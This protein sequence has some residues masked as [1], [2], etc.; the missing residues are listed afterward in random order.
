M[1]PF[2]NISVVSVCLLLLSQYNTKLLPVVD[3]H[4]LL[5]IG[6][7]ITNM[8]TVLMAVSICKFINIVD[9]SN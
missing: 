7:I 1:S 8:V 3:N 9:H 6:V 5:H 2:L 4:L